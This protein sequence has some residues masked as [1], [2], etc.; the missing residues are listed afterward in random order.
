MD[1]GSSDG[2][3]DAVRASDSRITVIPG[4]GNLYWLHGILAVAEEHALSRDCE[5]L[6][7]LNDDVVL[8]NDGVR[9]LLEIAEAR[10]NT[11]IVV[12][13]VPTPAQVS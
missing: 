1:D 2:T 13:A 7:W 12:G 10:E 6:L 4:T 3:S 8:D 11:C 5:H 9:R